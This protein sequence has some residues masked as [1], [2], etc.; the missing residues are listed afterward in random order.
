MKRFALCCTIAALFVSS[1]WPQASTGT[2]RGTVRDQTEAAI[3]KASVSLTNTATN[4]ALRSTSNEVGFFLFAGVLP[5]PYRLSAEAPGMQKFEAT[6]TVQVQQVAVVDPV[7][8]VGQTVTAVEV[9]DVNPLLTVDTPVLGHVLERQRIEQLPINGRSVFSLLQ[10]VPGMEG[11]RAYGLREGSHEIVLDGAAQTDKLWG[12]TQRRPPG[13]DTIQEFK[14]ENNASSAKFTRPTTVVMLTRSGT[15]NVHGALFET[16]RNNGIGKARRREDYY[17]KPPQ[18]IRNEYGGWAGGPVILPRLYTG[19]DRTFWFFSYEGLRLTSPTTRGVS[20]PTEAMRQGDFRGL[21]DSQ[22]RQ[23]RIYDPFTTNTQ[24]WE[25]QQVA[26]QGQLNVIDP[27]RISPLAK[28][29]IEVSP[30]PTHPAT[31]PLVEANWWG[32]VPDVRRQWTLTSRF[33]H[34]FSDN[35]RFYARYTQGGDHRFRYPFGTVPTSDR[36]AGTVTN[37]APNR[38]LAASWVRTFSPTLFNE[39]LVTGSREFWTDSTGEFG[40]KYAD[41]LGLPNPFNVAGWPGLYDT[42][43]SNY[44]FETGNPQATAFTFLILDDNVTRIKG[45]HELQFGVHLRYDQM[46]YM[47]DQQHPQGNHNWSTGGT[48][49]Y[50]PTSSRTNPLGTPFAGHNLANMY[51]GVMNYSNQFVR[52]YFYARGREYAFYFQDNYKVTS[53]LTLNLG[54]RWEYWP[55]FGEK[56]NVLTTFDPNRR[57]V[58]LGQDLDAMYRLGATLPSIVDRL[59]FLGVKF[60]T[61]KEAG[62][63]RALRQSTWRDLGPRLGFAY[64]A[65]DGARSFVLRGGYRISYFPIPM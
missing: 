56:N 18:L 12:G 17:T 13:L 29:L 11:T 6:L 22:G 24:T 61:A 62:M 27:N 45:R 19:K 59:Q 8:R 65:G 2:V 54:L 20:V 43:L 31:N 44:Y 7:L 23:F 60:T 52:G 35:D 34:A 39:L 47:P 28:R 3:P 36:V 10:T 9:R 50:D 40:V 53:R 49:L 41:Q 38:S 16:H 37:T 51:F 4:V 46:N 1:A 55:P 30:L 5:G 15:N 48:G 25:R 26:H 32:P 64:R 42:G 14:V 33:D 57:A 58:V 63:P 21:M